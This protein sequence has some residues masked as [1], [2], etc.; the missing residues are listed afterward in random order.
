MARS[1]PTVESPAAP[2]HQPDNISVGRWFA[3]YALCLVCAGA[4]LAVLISRQGW[5]WSTWRE[6]FWC[7]LRATSPA[8]KLIVFGVYISLCC[9][10]LPMPANAMAGVVAIQ[11]TAVCSGAAATTLVVAAVGGAASAI[12]NLNDYHLLTLLLRHRKVA[13]V[14]DTRLYGVSARWFAKSPFTILVTFNIIPI[15][16]GVIRILATICRYPRLRFA[17]AN[18]IGRFIR[19]GVIAYV[20]Y[21]LGSQGWVAPVAL[22]AVAAVFAAVRIISSGLRKLHARRSA[23]LLSRAAAQE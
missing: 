3:F 7:Q 19:Y 14:R 13:R 2:Q 6:D 23:S 4:A 9:T 21:R 16:V 1:L 22:L 5:S 17:L 12:A 10:F 11:D 18:F 15:P 8:V 20:T